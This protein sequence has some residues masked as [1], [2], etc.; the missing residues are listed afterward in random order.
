MALS[1]FIFFVDL[2]AQMLYFFG[3]SHCKHGNRCF[4]NGYSILGTLD[5]F[6]NSCR[7]RKRNIAIDKPEKL[8]ALSHLMEL[9][10]DEEGE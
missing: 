4:S 1:S 6:C 3:R 5:Q 9:W 8:L 7:Y 2:S 10:V